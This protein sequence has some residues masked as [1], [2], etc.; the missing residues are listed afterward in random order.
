MGGCVEGKSSE[1]SR[2]VQVQFYNIEQECERKQGLL[3]LKQGGL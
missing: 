1:G 3:D 2:L